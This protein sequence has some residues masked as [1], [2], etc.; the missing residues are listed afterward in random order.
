MTHPASDEPSLAAAPT[1]DQLADHPDLAQ[2]LPH[3][4]A[5]R[6]H[7]KAQTVATACALALVSPPNGEGDEL[8]GVREAA[9]RIGVSP[10]TLAHR[11]RKEPYS[12]FLVPTGSRT[13]RFSARAIREW[14]D[15]ARQQQQTHAGSPAAPPG[16]PPQERKRRLSP[17]ARPPYPWLNARQ[18]RTQR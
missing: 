13:L 7:L 12:R 16:E 8:L 14:Q 10:I 5:F 4:I 17:T 1:L 6:L 15:Q 18:G 11:A 9:R 3:E 2:K